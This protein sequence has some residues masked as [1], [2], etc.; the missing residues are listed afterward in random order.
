M[1]QASDLIIR[2]VNDDFFMLQI[3]DIFIG[4]KERTV[5][6]IALSNDDATKVTCTYEGQLGDRKV[7]RTGEIEI[8][9]VY[10][11]LF[12]KVKE[13]LFFD[14]HAEDQFGQFVLA[15]TSR[16]QISEVTGITDLEDR[17][18]HVAIN[19]VTAEMYKR[20]IDDAGDIMYN[21]IMNNR[22]P[23]QEPLLEL[24]QQPA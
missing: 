23:V 12:Y 11:A 21:A 4:N 17:D 19:A 1:K 22:L 2:I 3:D 10:K 13:L 18:Y 15:M 5:T 6:L 8:S 9:K 14:T 24:E 7:L 16:D 20:I